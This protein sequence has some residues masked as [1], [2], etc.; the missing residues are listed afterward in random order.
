LLGLVNVAL[1]GMLLWAGVGLSKRKL[2]AA[3]MGIRICNVCCIFEIARLLLG[4]WINFH[5]FKTFMSLS[6]I[7]EPDGVPIGMIMAVSIV[8][9]F[10]FTLLYGVGKIIMYVLCARF[11]SKPHVQAMLA[12]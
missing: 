3:K 11:L 7:S 8:A 9:G 4:A 2:S 12:T 10:V 6:Q 5:A 1:S